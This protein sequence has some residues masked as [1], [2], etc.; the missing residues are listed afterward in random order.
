M[1]PDNWNFESVGTVKNSAKSSFAFTARSLHDILSAVFGRLYLT[2]FPAASTRRGSL[3]MVIRGGVAGGGAT[4]DSGGVV[5]LFGSSPAAFMESSGG[6]VEPAFCVSISTFHVNLAPAAERF[7]VFIK[8][9]STRA[10]LFVINWAFPAGAH[11][12]VMQP[13]RSLVRVF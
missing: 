1:Q 4:G 5:V 8:R 2:G 12:S 10:K 3:A 6:V 13:E 11:P 7:K 9:R